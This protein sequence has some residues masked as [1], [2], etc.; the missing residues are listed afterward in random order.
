MRRKIGAAPATSE[1]GRPPL[2]NAKQSSAWSRIPI[3]PSV[4]VATIR[5]QAMLGFRG[6]H[7]ALQGTGVPNAPHQLLHARIAGETRELVT[8]VRGG[9]HGEPVQHLAQGRPIN[10]RRS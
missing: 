6:R 9:Q 1:R 8:I 3:K 2:K 4:L 7:F 5:F 10:S